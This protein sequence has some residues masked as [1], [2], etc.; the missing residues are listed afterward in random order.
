MTSRQARITFNEVVRCARIVECTIQTMG[1]EKLKSRTIVFKPRGEIL[2]NLSGT[3]KISVF[4]MEC[5][6]ETIAKPEPKI[7]TVNGWFVDVDTRIYF[8]DSVKRDVIRTTPV[9]TIEGNVV[10]TRSGSKYALGKMDILIAKR[11]ASITISESAPLEEDT[12]PFL[13][14]AAYDVYPNFTDL[15]GR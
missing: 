6:V 1:T 10:T 2:S 13:V 15:Y 9:V 5:T 12:L 4:S 8:E 3:A 11:L 7:T 14:N